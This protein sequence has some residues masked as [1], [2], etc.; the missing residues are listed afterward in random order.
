MDFD[1]TNKQASQKHKSKGVLAT[2]YVVRVALMSA[3]LTALKFALSFVPNVE[4]VTLLV[5]VYGCVFGVKYA[6]PA[7]L[8]FC[9][10]EIATYGVQSWV[11]L[12]FVYWP[13]LAIVSSGLLHKKT[14]RK[15]C[16]GITGVKTLARDYIVGENAQ[17]VKV[18]L[19]ANKP[20][21]NRTSLK[22]MAIALA[23]GGVGSILFGVLSASADT[24]FCVAS[25]APNQLGA[26]WVAYYLRGITFDLIH[27]ASSVATILVGFLPLV[28][29]GG[30]VARDI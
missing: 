11:I 23:I 30:V 25:L 22:T 19:V 13:M 26:Y 12:Y 28:K 20:S 5:V 14:K 7:T 18:T 10:V 27:L 9:G 21:K 1:K 3:M 29:L 2:F 4:V 17:G 24:I 6:L 8:I 16:A 15:K